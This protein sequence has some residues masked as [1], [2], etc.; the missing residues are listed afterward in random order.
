[1]C[2]LRLIVHSGIVIFVVIVIHPVNFDAIFDDILDVNFDAIFDDTLDV[3]FDAI[4]D[5]LDVKFDAI[6]TPF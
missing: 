3:N 2:S 6:L 4:F 1:M 5:I